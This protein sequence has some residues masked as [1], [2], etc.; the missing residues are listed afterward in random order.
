VGAAGYTA[1]VH[2]RP[3][4]AASE[5]HGTGI[6]KRHAR[7]ASGALPFDPEEWA[8]AEPWE[9]TSERRALARGLGLRAL[10]QRL[11][12]SARRLLAARLD[13]ETAVPLFLLEYRLPW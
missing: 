13:R 12:E 2:G 6:L 3:L 9:P 11:G 8:L 1:I 4:L 10:E 7:V 5:S